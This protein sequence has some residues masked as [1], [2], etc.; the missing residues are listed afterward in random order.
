MNQNDRKEIIKALKDMRY[1]QAEII[2]IIA[3]IEKED[4]IPDVNYSI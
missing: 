2:A 4:N 1:N 3:A